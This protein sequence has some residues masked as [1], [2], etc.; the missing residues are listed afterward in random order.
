MRPPGRIDTDASPMDIRCSVKRRADGHTMDNEPEIPF[1][2]VVE[3]PPADVT[4]A[5]QLGRTDLLV[6]VSTG[7][8]LVF[9]FRLR[10]KRG[11]A[12]QPVFLGPAA[13]GPPRDRFVY[14]NSGRMAGQMNS[15]WTRRAKVRLASI[16]AS[17]A[18]RVLSHPGS[19]LEARIPGLGRDGGPSCGTTRPPSGIWSFLPSL[20][21]PS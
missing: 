19:G 6:P 15:P 9:D 11:A 1:R 12:V 20:S 14:V 18:E 21:R 17:L 5:V 13:Q 7:G 2:I 8:D 3:E 10:L 4:F 16:D